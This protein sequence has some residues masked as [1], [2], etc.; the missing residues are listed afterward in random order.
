LDK[1]NFEVGATQDE[2][3][4]SRKLL[5]IAQPLRFGG[6]IRRVIRVFCIKDRQ[7]ATKIAGF[8]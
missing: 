5:K 8:L 3:G 7:T 6:S 1:K 2:R 4:V